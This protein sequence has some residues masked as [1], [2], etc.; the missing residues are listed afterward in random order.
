M[1]NLPGVIAP[2]PWKPHD[3]QLKATR[4]V[5]QHGCS[6]LFLDPGLGK[7]SIALAAIKTLRRTKAMPEKQ[8][9]LLI[10]PLRPIYNVWDGNNPE[11][12]PR[13]WTDF[14]MLTTTL[15][16]GDR[17][18]EALKKRSD[19][20]LINPDGLE[21]LVSRVRPGSAAWPFYGLIVD[22]STMFKHANTNRFG[23]LKSLLPFFQ[24]RVILTGYP[25]PNGLMDLFGQI[26]ILDLGNALGRYITHYRRSYF[27]PTGY[28]GYTWVPQ[29]GA[30]ERIYK[31]VEPLVLRM[32]EK[33]Y[34]KLPRLVG[35][36]AHEKTKPN[37]IRIKLPPKARKAYDQLE[38]IFFLE[39][40]S[41]SVT[42]SNAGVKSVKL[43]QVANG[44][45]YID[46]GGEE[47]QPGGKRMWQLIHEAKSDAV[48][49]L[50]EELSGRPAAI[51]FEFAHDLE[52]LRMH[53]DL[54]N[55]PAIGEGSIKD[56]TL[57]ARDFNAGK[58]PGLFVNPASF[59]RGSNMQAG[60]DAL[61]WHSNTYN[62]EFYDQLIRRFWR[63]GR[64]RPFFVHHII[65]EDTVDLAMTY[66]INRK[67]KTQGG[68]LDALRNY[69]F[70]RP[71]RS[72]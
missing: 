25:A 70:R 48:A 39:L 3:Y 45:I 35:A 36:L 9:F 12:E 44:G 65:A 4:W 62:Y 20:Y 54:K 69:S 28:G 40:E 23:L 31:R 34:L 41:G 16:H 10:G 60:A 6:G 59:A 32:S 47:L 68:L 52:R 14:N 50:L 30:E 38:E 2:V 43:R 63:Q 67:S 11:S 22:E 18:D 27:N 15:L 64:K 33:D 42:A 29:E 5:L 51:A 17:K 26:Y 46:K 8:G 13:K 49:G 53:R 61:I 58:F 55:I 72:S 1:S 7:S 66:A 56:D 37:L 21:W 71:R 19:I 57:L 24:R